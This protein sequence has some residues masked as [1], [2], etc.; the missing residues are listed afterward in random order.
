MFIYVVTFLFIYVFIFFYTTLHRF[1]C[2]DTYTL[3]ILIFNMQRYYNFSA[4]L[5]RTLRMEVKL[6]HVGL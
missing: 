2:H 6:K 5:M 4:V 3:N 1:V